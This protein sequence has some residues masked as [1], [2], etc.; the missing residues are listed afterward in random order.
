MTTGRINQ[1]AAA[2]CLHLLHSRGRPAD[3]LGVCCCAGRHAL[4]LLLFGC[5]RATPTR[6]GGARE[7]APASRLG[8]S[9][10]RAA[11]FLPRG[12]RAD[13]G[14]PSPDGRKASSNLSELR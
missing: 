10:I 4:S 6:P 3:A 2:S 13:P 14:I 8:R 1:G 7:R 5:R 9:E 11:R 12:T